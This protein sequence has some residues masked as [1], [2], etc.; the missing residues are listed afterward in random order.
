MSAG[1]AGRVALRAGALVGAVVFVQLLARIFDHSWIPRAVQA[2]G[3][4]SGCLSALFAVGLVLVYRANRIINFAHASFGVVALVGYIIMR[5]AEGWSWYIAFPAALAGAAVIGMTIELA[6]VRRFSKAPRLAL[7]VLT[8]GVSQFLVGAVGIATGILIDPD[9][10]PVGTLASPFSRWRW[11]WTPVVFSGDHVAILVVTVLVFA[12]MAAFFK[13]SSLG[14]AIRGSAENDDRAAMLGVNTHTLSTFVWVAAAALSAIAALLQAPFQGG[15]IGGGIATAA[16]AAGF[17][18]LLRALAAAVIGRMENLPDTIAAAIGIALFEQGVLWAFEDSAIVDG[19]LLLLVIAVFLVQ[20]GQL[21]R[22]V[23]SVTGTWSATKEVRA[24]PNE[25][26]GLPSVRTGTR[27]IYF[28]IAVVVLG[29]PWVMDPRQTSLGGIIAIYGIIAISLVVLTGWGGQI[30]LGQYGFVAVGAVIGGALTSKSGWP[31]IP[32]ALV[33]CLA[34]AAVAVLLG[35]PALRIRGLFLAVTTLA[36]SVAVAT[37]FLN[38]RFF[39]WLIPT[40]NVKRPRLL[41]VNF[42][43]E[44]VY[45]YLCI[46]GLAFAIFLAQGLRRSR[47]GRVLIAMRDNELAAQSFSVNLVRTRLATFAISGFLASFAGVLLVHHQHGVTQTAFPPELSIQM[48]L[49]AVIGGLGSVSGVLVGAAYIGALN[50]FVTDSF[51]QLLLTG[52]S[53]LGILVFY[54]GGLG[55]MVFGVRDAWLRRVAMRNRI[56]VPSLVGDYR[57]LDGERARVPLAPKFAADGSKAVLP[58]QYRVDSVIRQ[59][60]ASQRV[61]VWR[62]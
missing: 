1:R 20:R 33:T 10:P 39:G 42:E 41:W 11:D 51:W 13:F 5:G 24:I 14:V 55:A 40:R 45:Y 48:F 25:L 7:T 12:G 53:L 62:G 19:A 59:R 6:L 2:R 3:V 49:L 47:A 38:Q 26:Q 56:F 61:R 52:G 30:S 22:S 36:F 54:P 9:D 21:S 57:I 18:L 29:Y 23:Q 15:N 43:D 34:G 32:A 16:N 17:G 8:L 58:R 37:V 44:R 4:M 35:I 50:I 28:L 46:A 60:G 31:F 27:R